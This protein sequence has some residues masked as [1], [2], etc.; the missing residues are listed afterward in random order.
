MPEKALKSVASKFHLTVDQ[1]RRILELLD[2]GY[3]IPYIM[4]YHK[5]LAA[6]LEADNF[7][8][9][10][11]ERARLEKLESRRRKILKKLAERDVLTEELEQ[12]IEQAATVRELIDYYVPYR[13]RKRSRSRLAL[14]QG[15]GPLATEVLSQEEFIA[16]MAAAAEP[17]VDPEH[18]L[19]D[20]EDV[21]EG[22]FYIVADWVAEEKTHRDRQREVLREEGEIV[23][24]RARRSLPGRLVR[25][26]RQYFDYRQPVSKLHPYHMLV[27]LRGK[28]MKALDYNVEPPL[29]AMKRAAADLYLA[30]GAAQFEQIV[31]ELGDTVLTN[32]GED[33]K[34]L[35]S[36]E[37]LVSAIRYSLENILAS[38]VA[39][40]L[41]KELSKEAESLALEIIRRNVKS[42][43]MVRPIKERVLAVHPGYRTGC[44]LAALD[45][46]GNVLETATAYPH[47]PQNER[48]EAVE[49]ISRLIEEHDLKVAAIGG[50][51]GTEET[52]DLIGEM[53]ADRFPELKYTVIQEVGLDAYST[54]R[55]AAGELGEMEPA[56]RCAVAI[57]RRLLD[58]LSELVKINARQLCPS[59]YVDDVNGGALKTLLDRLLEECVCSI[60]VDANRAH[61]SLLRYVSGLDPEKAVELVSH[62]D[63]RGKLSSREQV[64]HVPK[65]DKDSYERAIGFM[66][67][68]GSDNPLDV[69]RVHPKF[70]PVAER[71]CQE[72]EIPLDRLA[73]EEGRAEL[74]Q[75]RSELQ[76]TDLEKEFDVHYLLLKDIVD[77]M[78][79]PWP[80]PR[81]QEPAPVLRDKRLSLA[82]LEPDQ[83]LDG[84]VRNIVDFGVF[85][86]I[87][88]GEDGLIHISELADRYIE[89]PYDV[90][91]VGDRVRVRVVRVDEERSRIALSLREESPERARG[92]T[93]G[94]KRERKETRKEARPAAAASVPDKK[95]GSAVRTPRSTVGMDS[96]RVQKASLSDRLSKT[97]QQMLKKSTPEGE[98]PAADDEERKEE[99]GGEGLL[100]KLDF[101]SIERR[102]KPSD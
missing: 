8:E 25:E 80:D 50:G 54:S 99:A 100:G 45:E 3:S 38:I 49:T 6:N 23:A 52:E 18:E 69:T 88:V 33:L 20:V 16:D 4:R 19:E 74:Q 17:Y 85:V 59:P 42:M 39:R 22:V 72:L 37:F 53:I 98:E 30:G 14:S 10:I 65:I 77:E 73:D 5:E 12:K 34:K 64:R 75:K 87:G 84:T 90:V 48:E 83:W 71:I 40:E 46:E 102:G 66:R 13:P 7:Y 2:E 68:E 95:P 56:E 91:C 101:A 92:R 32:Q 29:E 67:V 79:R 81:Q 1:V 61:Y 63:K 76:L 93:G 82:D 97:K 70:Y 86:D 60:G 31:S 55:A 47:P 28:R 43:L 26:F 24:R 44:N 89:T 11:E 51:T 94:E 58:P 41:D 62:R 57:G 27:I 21:L 9:L 96:R 78:V 15:L 36:A 35:N